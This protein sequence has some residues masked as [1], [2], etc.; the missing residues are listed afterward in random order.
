MERQVLRVA[1]LIAAV[2]VA[3]VLGFI[4]VAVFGA[5]LSLVDSFVFAAGLLAGMVPEGLLPVITLA[6]A[7]SVRSLTTH[8]ALPGPA[9]HG[10]PPAQ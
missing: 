6:L 7:V 4:P 10:R 8:G 2:S 9:R 5:R 1:W 3:L